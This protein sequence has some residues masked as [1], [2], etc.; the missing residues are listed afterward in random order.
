MTPKKLSDFIRANIAPILRRWEQFA[1]GIASARHMST[2]ARRDHASGILIS[3]AA[4]LDRS[5]TPHEQMEKSKGRGPRSAKETYASM[6]GTDRVSAGFSVTEAVSEFR[7][8]RAS[9]LQLW[10]SSNTTEPHIASDEL[11]RFNE[12]IDQALAES[13]ERYSTDLGRFTCL[14]DTLLSSSPDL[15]YIFDADGRFIYVNKSL[16]RLYDTTASEIVGKNFIDLGASNA[17][18]LQQ[19][20]RQVIDTTTTYR[21]EMSSTLSSGKKMT[22]EYLFVP[23]LDEKGNLD[24][25]VATERD[26]TERKASVEKIRRSANYDSLTGLP[27]RSLFSERLEWEVKRSTRTGLPIALL[28]IDLDSFKEVN[29]R[30][31]HAA[32]D[33]LLQQAGQRISACVRSTDTVARLGGDEFTVI[34]TEVNKILHVEI[35]AQKILEELARSFSIFQTDVHIS[36]SIGITLFPEDAA[37]PEYLIRNADQAMYLAK[38]AG[39]N[40]FSF[41]TTGM[42]DSAWE[43]LKVIEELRHAL[44]QKQLSVYYQPIV[45]L[46]LGHIVKAE[47]LVRWHHPRTGLMLPAEFISLAEETG[48]ISEIGDWVM[49]EAV[50]C[51]REWSAL[52]GVP[53]QISV[54]KSPVEFMSKA[55]MKII[56][57]HLTALG[58]AWNSISVEITEGLLLNDSPNVR[59]KLDGLQ[60]AGI[61]LAIDDFGTGHSSMVYL[62]KFDVDCLKI[63]QSF[64]R[65]MATSSNSRIIAETIIVMAHKLGLKVIA[66]GVETGEQRDWLIAS[67]CDYAQGYLFSK[68]VTARDFEKLL[69]TE[70]ALQQP[71]PQPQPQSV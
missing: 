4:D 26:I 25:I 18:A 31:G 64:V 24:A 51:A 29:D 35:L 37:T 14:F 47:A 6:H 36:G 49:G 23:V 28:F 12:A 34:L 5:Q 30:M 7:A 21:G 61:Q 9:V 40:R 17:A 39:R 63:D 71:Q 54:N 33:Q 55:P 11:I 1:K 2:A 59:E 46:S 10:S 66:E 42:R 8:L 20:L 38:N 44:P 65:D 60:K 50:A 15:N 53:F 58:V 43:R 3:I 19:Q 13:L 56:D 27:N 62:K 16:A 22:C 45:D 48:L 41:F 67:H 70:K 68:P 52:Q 32:G 69:K 57:S